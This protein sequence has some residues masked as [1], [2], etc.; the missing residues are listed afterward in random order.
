M[1]ALL[2]AG[3]VA[4]ALWTPSVAHARSGDGGLGDPPRQESLVDE[5]ATIV[6]QRFYSRARLAQV[7]WNKALAHARVAYSGTSDPAVRISVVR[8]LLATLGTSHTA[9]YPREDPGYW[10]MA[11]IFEPVL[12]KTCAKQRLPSLPISHEDIGVLWKRV[13]DEWF[14]GG[15]HAVWGRVRD[16]S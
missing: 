6:E 12:S 11:S 10:A 3:I 8:S 2:L 1:T 4:T 5:V 9:F 16:L 14:V 13:G 7:G 15:V